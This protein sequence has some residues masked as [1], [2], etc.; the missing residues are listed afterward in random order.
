MKKKEKKRKNTWA[1]DCLHLEP[2]CLLSLDLVV[3]AMLMVDIFC[4]HS[5]QVV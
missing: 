5:L 3:M 4:C 2:L 1:Q